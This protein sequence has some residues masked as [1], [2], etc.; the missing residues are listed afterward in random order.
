MI[1]LARS[2]LKH[3]GDV[4]GFK[5]RIVRDDFVATG[6]GS[7]QIQHVTHADAHATNARA[8]TALLRVERDAVQEVWAWLRHN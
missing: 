5:I 3:G 2:V 1:A 7:K 6:T 8:T 4:V